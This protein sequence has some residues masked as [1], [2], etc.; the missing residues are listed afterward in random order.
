LA[1]IVEEVEEVEGV[2]GVEETSPSTSLEESPSLEE[3]GEVASK[4]TSLGFK[5]QASDKYI[6]K[7]LTVPCWIR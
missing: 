6:K 2:E 5:T 1:E 7:F 4:F 3:E